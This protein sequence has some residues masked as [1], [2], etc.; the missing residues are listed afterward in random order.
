MFTR[1]HLIIFCKQIALQEI[2]ALEETIKRNTAEVKS[3]ENLVEQYRQQATKTR[4]VKLKKV[5]VRIAF[6]WVYKEVSEFCCQQRQRSM[7]HIKY[8]MFV[9]LLLLLYL[10]L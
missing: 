6:Q 4:L 9:I 1:A 2:E 7:E 8:Y 5:S 3:S 10:T